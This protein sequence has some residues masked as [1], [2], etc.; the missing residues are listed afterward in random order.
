MLDGSG[1]CLA[2]AESCP[3]S[4]VRQA[5]TP[6][7]LDELRGLGRGGLAGGRGEG[8]WPRLVCTSPT[9]RAFGSA[10]CPWLPTVSALAPCTTSEEPRP[11][12]GPAR[13]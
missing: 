12:A 8:H 6:I 5:E 7:G 3:A 9:P 4:G 11:L 1:C 13:P 10:Q 2:A